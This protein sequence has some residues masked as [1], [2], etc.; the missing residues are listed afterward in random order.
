[1]SEDSFLEAKFSQGAR[2]TAARLELTLEDCASEVWSYLTQPDRL[3][4]WL[5]PGRI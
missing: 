2:T 4:Q 1:M 3:P 5:A